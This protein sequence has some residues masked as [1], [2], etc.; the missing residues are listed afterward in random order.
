MVGLKFCARGFIGV[1]IDV[2]QL[3]GAVD[4]GSDVGIKS[5]RYGFRVDHCPREVWQGS[6]CGLSKWIAESNLFI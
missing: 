3:R 6:G 4:G 2:M 1:P 5:S